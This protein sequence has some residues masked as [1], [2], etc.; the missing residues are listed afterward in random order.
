[1]QDGIETRGT[2]RCPVCRS[3]RFTQIPMSVYI[4]GPA[5]DQIPFLVYRCEI[6]TYCSWF[7]PFGDQQPLFEIKPQ[8]FLSNDN[9]S[10]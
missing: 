1:M 8:P 4:Q 3:L 5:G 6:C 7:L 10:P 9:P 2:V